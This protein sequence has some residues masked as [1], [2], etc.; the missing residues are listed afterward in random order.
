[1]TSEFTDLGLGANRGSDDHVCNFGFPGAVYEAA[2]FDWINQISAAHP[3]P[4]A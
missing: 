4:I 3:S 2:R 1:M